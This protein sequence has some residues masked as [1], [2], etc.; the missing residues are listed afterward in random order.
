VE[1]L[2]RFIIIIIIII[3]VRYFFLININLGHTVLIKINFK[4]N[5]KLIVESNRQQILS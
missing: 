2:V 3:I 5:L 1:K 4:I